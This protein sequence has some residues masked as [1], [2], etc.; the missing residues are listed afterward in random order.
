MLQIRSSALFSKSSMRVKNT[1]PTVAL[2]GRMNVGKS[3]LFNALTGTRKAFTSSQKGT[4]KDRIEETVC[5]RGREFHLVDTGG[6]D[7]HDEDVLY[8]TRQAIQTADILLFLTDIREGVLPTDTK[9]AAMLKKTKK[10]VVLVCNKADSQKHLMFLAEFYK[11]GLGDPH[12]I[13]A[14]T[15]KGTGDLLDIIVSLIQKKSPSNKK[16]IRRSS[17]KKI[18]RVSLIGKPNVG[19]STLLNVLAG[20]NRMIVSPIPM[21]TQ[22]PQDIIISY[23]NHLLQI[24]DTAGLKRKA[25]IPAGLQE[26]ASRASIR[27][28]RN[29]DIILFLVDISSEITSQDVR[30]ARSIAQTHAGAIIVANKWDL[31]QKNHPIGK[32]NLKTFLKDKLIP[33]NW[34]PICF[35]SAKTGK[36]VKNVLDLIIAVEKRK[37]AIIPKSQLNEFIK[38]DKTLKKSPVISIQQMEQIPSEFRVIVQKNKTLQKSFLRFIQKKLRETFD[39]EGVNIKM[40]IVYQQEKSGI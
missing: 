7:T 21:T 31:L 29:T 26:A 12:P 35:L 19:K 38:R 36:N 28:M 16:E 37:Q 15:G 23:K 17:D 22:E 5:W 25:K 13:S 14:A 8:Q 32:D 39:L 9:L 10:P 20:E 34:A 1:L 30:L 11:L 27:E 33:L 24:V 3:T 6:A 18:T 4:T 2:V 40:H